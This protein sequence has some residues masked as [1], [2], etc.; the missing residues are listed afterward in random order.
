VAAF[1]HGQWKGD[2]WYRPLPRQRFFESLNTQTVE[3]SKD[4]SGSW[5]K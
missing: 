1:I 5:G 2:Y 4:E 3:F